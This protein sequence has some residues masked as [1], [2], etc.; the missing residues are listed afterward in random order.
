M[1]FLFSPSL[2]SMS[3]EAVRRAQGESGSDE[4]CEETSAQG[5]RGQLEKASEA[6]FGSRQTGKV[7]RVKIRADI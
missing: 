1:R 6:T 4:R 3:G 2:P 5:Q 7:G